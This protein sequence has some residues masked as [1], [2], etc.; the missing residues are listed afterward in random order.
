[1][2]VSIATYDSR[3]R[4]RVGSACSSIFHEDRSVP[5]SA[6]TD[7]SIRS[8]SPLGFSAPRPTGPDPFP[9]WTGDA[10]ART[11]S[12]PT[13]VRL[14]YRDGR[15]LR[16]FHPGKR[17]EAMSL[18]RP[19]GVLDPRT[20]QR[21][22]DPVRHRRRRSLGRRSRST[23]GLPDW[24]PG[25]GHSVLMSFPRSGVS[26]LDD[27]VI[28]RICAERCGF[29]LSS[30]CSRSKPDPASFTVARLRGADGSW[31]V[32]GEAP[33]SIAPPLRR[34]ERSR[35]HPVFRPKG[36][37]RTFAADGAYREDRFLPPPG[38]PCARV[39]TFLAATAVYEGGQEA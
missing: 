23:R 34:T 16:Y 3:P 22:P 28:S 2:S 12:S 21:L 6:F 36:S 26:G 1:V 29:D 8:E 24:V 25:R 10:R 17:R 7:G 30:T 37:D 20:P 15:H 33:S 18:L 19:Y 31:N 38:P 11:R 14:V 4:P 27:L 5:S 32:S 13:S 35:V 39:V 9:L